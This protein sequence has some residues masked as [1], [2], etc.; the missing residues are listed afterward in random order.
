MK[1]PLILAAC[2]CVALGS[3]RFG[4]AVDAEFPLPGESGAAIKFQLVVQTADQPAEVVWNAFVDRWFDFFDRDG[5]GSLS[6][7]EAGRVLPLPLADQR[8]AVLQV[9]EFDQDGDGL[10]NRT[11]LKAFYRR[12]GFTPVVFHALPPTADVVEASERLFRHLDHDRNGILVDTELQRAPELFN[13]LDEDDDEVL[14]LAELLA[15]P[16]PQSAAPPVVNNIT[17]ESVSPAV[18]VVLNVDVSAPLQRPLV[19]TVPAESSGV[20]AISNSAEG[21]L[22]LKLGPDFCTV[23]I[24]PGGKTQAFKAARGFYLAQYRT[25]FGTGVPA[26]KSQLQ[27]DPALGLI[28]DLFDAADRDGDGKLHLDE[29]TAFLDLIEQGIACQ[30]QAILDSHGRSLLE[31]LDTSHD[32]RLVR[33]ELHAAGRV[34]TGEWSRAGISRH[35]IPVQFQLRIERG[36]PGL[37]FGSVPIPVPARR[38]NSQQAIDNAAGPRWFRSLDRNGDA[39]LSPREFPGKSEQFERLD[40]DHDGMISIEEAGP[41]T[42]P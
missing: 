34:L 9:P 28:A 31:L 20:E 30:T 23:R 40:R 4:F 35:Q 10:G 12:A 3:A 7:S 6:A 17:S 19:S 15:L 16:G 38:Q 22:R 36:P 2:L 8:Q 11:E 29:L 25:A 27:Q 26:V 24:E 33:S 41:V 32:G 21:P 37:V 5:N 18:N 14:T 39:S 42:A 13:R 1:S